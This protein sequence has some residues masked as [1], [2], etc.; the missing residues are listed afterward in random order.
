MAL[1]VIETIALIT[2]VVVLIKIVVILIKPKAWLSV[3]RPIYS[4]PVVLMIVSLVLAAVVLNYLILAGITITQIFAVMGFGALL[5]AMTA[6]S[7]AKEVV[8]LGTKML[9]DRA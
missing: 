8:A 3:V 9:K 6:A 4:M 5:G 1:G 2:A 7:Y